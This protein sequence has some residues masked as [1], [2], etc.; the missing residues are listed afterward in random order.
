MV[1]KDSLYGYAIPWVI[2]NPPKMGCSPT[3]RPVWSFVDVHQGY[4]VHS[5]NNGCVPLNTDPDVN[6]MMMVPNWLVK[7]EGRT[8]PVTKM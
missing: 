7:L 2:T 5:H 8:Y 6:S 1:S 3:V 4:R